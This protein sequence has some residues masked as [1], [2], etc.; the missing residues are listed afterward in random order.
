MSK[1]KKKLIELITVT[2]I[3]GTFMANNSCDV[4]NNRFLEHD[5]KKIN[6]LGMV[7]LGKR[8]ILVKNRNGKPLQNINVYYLS[9]EKNEIVLAVDPLR[10]YYPEKEEFSKLEPNKSALIAETILIMDFVE[11]YNNL[12]QDTTKGPGKLLSIEENTHRYCSTMDNLENSVVNV[13]FGIISIGHTDI[14][15]ALST[16]IKTIF[17]NYVE[18][19]FGKHEGYEVSVPKESV[20]ICGSDYDNVVCTID[21]ESLSRKVWE[22]Q[23]MPYWKIN[24]PCNLVEKEIDNNYGRSNDIIEDNPVNDENHNNDV[25]DT[26]C[27]GS[28]IYKEGKCLQKRC[29][30]N[31][32]CSIGEDCIDACVTS[33]RELVT[34]ESWICTEDRECLYRRNA[35]RCMDVC[36]KL[37]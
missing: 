16:P 32:D 31:D 30:S 15:V 14:K 5:L 28:Q 19:Q 10:D 1:L 9:D 11:N 3:S 18:K 2:L 29:F 24:G 23:G 20:N 8:N 22:P 6:S 26:N 7:E 35:Y 4:I 27:E 12:H 13:P 17:R 34:K 25:N 21:S 37:F 33:E 36:V